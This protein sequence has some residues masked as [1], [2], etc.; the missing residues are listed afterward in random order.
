M[1]KELKEFLLEKID[2]MIRE[3]EDKIRELNGQ[4]LMTM[5]YK[6]PFLN[7]YKIQIGHYPI[8]NLIEG[9]IIK[10]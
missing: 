3:N 5:I 4:N 9:I 2:V 6:L 8:R 7:S 10:D 1:N